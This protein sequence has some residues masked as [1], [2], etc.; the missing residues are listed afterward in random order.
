MEDIRENNLVSFVISGKQAAGYCD[1]AREGEGETYDA[2][3]PRCARLSLCGP[4]VEVNDPD[5]IEV[6]KEAMFSRHPVMKTWYTSDDTEDSHRFSFWRL[7]LEEIWL[8][9]FYGGAAQISIDA[10]DRGTDEEGQFILPSRS[11]M[12]VEFEDNATTMLSQA[13]VTNDRQYS[14]PLLPVLGRI[15]IFFV[16]LLGAFILG[17]YIGRTTVSWK[18]LKRLE[19]G[20][21]DPEEER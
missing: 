11:T 9:D 19:Q 18:R 7:E 21:I 6:A 10:W 16:T 17:T 8:V 4:L 13:E 14:Q 15:N 3:D 20:T 5:E 2:E 12:E 1:R